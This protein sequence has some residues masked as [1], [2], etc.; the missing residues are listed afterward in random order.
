[1]DIFI[2]TYLK[3]TT[4]T[5]TSSEN[6]FSVFVFFICKQ[7]LYKLDFVKTFSKE[8]E[9]RQEARPESQK[10][11]EEAEEREGKEKEG[12]EKRKRKLAQ[13]KRQ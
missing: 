9:E 6:I 8:V 11:Q 10:A 2:N 13:E 3:T 4:P 5:K 12:R 1:M 7:L